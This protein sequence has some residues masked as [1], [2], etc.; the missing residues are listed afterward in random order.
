MLY[1]TEEPGYMI[2]GK[3]MTG[4]IGKTWIRIMKDGSRLYIFPR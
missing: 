1:V 4:F 3:A 2:T